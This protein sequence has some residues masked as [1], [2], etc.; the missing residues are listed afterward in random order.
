[1][2]MSETSARLMLR[3][4]GRQ[5]QFTVEGETIIGSDRSCTVVIESS[6]VAGKHARIYRDDASKRFMIE[7]LGAPGTVRVDDS[8]VEA[9]YCL[10]SMSVITLGRDVELVFKMLAAV[11]ELPASRPA[12]SA[13]PPK[14]D[15][16]RTVPEGF[17]PRKIDPK[18]TVPEPFEPRKIDPKRTVPEAFEPRKPFEPRKTE[19]PVGGDK[20]IESPRARASRIN[21]VLIIQEPPDLAATHDLGEGDFLVGS[22]PQCAIRITHWSVSRKHA[23][24]IVREGAFRL[25]DLGST[26]G[27]FLDNRR[28]E[29]EVEL[30]PAATIGFG[31]VVA[32]LSSRPQ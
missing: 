15:P 14:I 2:T 6:Q 18:R 13:E 29:G 24:L 4:A 28:V 19:G 23:L 1:M 10:G 25:K 32:V 3:V 5:R 22:T 9:P 27:T 21:P 8:V 12:A 17:E 11:R 26:N 30:P 31:D 16:K 20:T 7:N